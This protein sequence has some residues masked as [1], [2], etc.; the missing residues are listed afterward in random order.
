MVC[1]LMH[2]KNSFRNVN[3]KKSMMGMGKMTWP[4]SA[5]RV[6][7][8]LHV[9]GQ[10]LYYLNSFYLSSIGKFI[11]EGVQKRFLNTSRRYGLCKNLNLEGL[12][13]PQTWLKTVQGQDALIKIVFSVMP[14]VGRYHSH[15][16]LMPAARKYAVLLFMHQPG[17]EKSQEKGCANSHW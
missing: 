3:L 7:T 17:I 12:P 5:W 9:Q 16:N 14:S 15:L 13:V 6:G 11:T 1:C 10:K 2:S 4:V 8:L